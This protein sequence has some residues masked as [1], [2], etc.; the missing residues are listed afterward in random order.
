MSHG[1]YDNTADDEPQAEPGAGEAAHDDSDRYARFDPRMLRE[2]V[3][4]TECESQI[5]AFYQAITA[6][7]D[8]R[9]IRM[10]SPLDGR[11]R[12]VSVT[13]TTRMRS[14]PRSNP[15]SQSH[16]PKRST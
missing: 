8:V 13:S 12:V 16:E 15:T 7:G 10:P 6:P 1:Q 9:E 14:S 5:R 4:W 3:G 2:P 11:K